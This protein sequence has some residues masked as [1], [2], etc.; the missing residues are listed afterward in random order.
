MSSHEEDLREYVVVKNDEEQ[1]SIWL[2][3]RAIPAGW[4][5]VGRA[6]TKQ[7]CL[8]HIKEVWTDMRPASL[9]DSG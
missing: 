3:H 7:E 9:R 6:G 1:Y 2:K 8:T 4:I 5:D